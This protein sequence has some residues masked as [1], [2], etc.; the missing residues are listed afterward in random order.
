MLRIGAD[1]GESDA[2]GEY[3]PLYVGG[4]VAATYKQVPD[5]KR[6]ED[7]KKHILSAYGIKPHVAWQRFINLRL[8]PSMTVDSLADE[9]RG[10]L[11]YVTTIDKTAK[12]DMVLQQMMVALPFETAERLRLAC[13]AADKKITLGTV[14]EKARQM[15]IRVEGTSVVAAFTGHQSYNKNQYT[16]A[17]KHKKPWEKNKTYNYNCNNGGMSNSNSRRDRRHALSPKNFG[18]VTSRISIY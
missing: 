16:A 7:V 18:K 9:L 10:C 6:Y 17:Y 13:E 1:C 4:L 11:E 14:L 5:P 15:T 2:R 12:D 8:T 3:L